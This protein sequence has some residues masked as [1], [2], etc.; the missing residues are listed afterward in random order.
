ME[1][2]A[3]IVQGGFAEM[4]NNFVAL[5]KDMDSRFNAVDIRLDG[6]DKRFD[7]ID[8]RLDGIDNRLDGVD[9]QISSLFQEQKETNRRLDS[10][11]RKQLG[12]L[13]SLDETV[14]R[15]EFSVLLRR[16]DVLEK[17]AVKK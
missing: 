14:H 7:G 6:M 8:N 17:K 12:L 9:S 16:V 3:R 15:N 10:I 1:S 11:E 4:Q 5:K 13:T 2:L